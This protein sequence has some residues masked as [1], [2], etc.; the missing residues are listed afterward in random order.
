MS[1]CPP[2]P[3]IA[4][5]DLPKYGVPPAFLAGFAVVPIE[6]YISTSGVLG[7]MGFM[8]RERGGTNPDGTA[9]YSNEILSDAGASYTEP[10]DSVYAAVTFTAGSYIH[11][12]TYSIDS[13]G[14]VTTSGSGPTITASRYDLPTNLCRAKTDEALTM[15]RP[16]VSPPL[17]A[18][19]DAVRSHAASLVYAALKRARGATPPSGG[20]SGDDL[21][22][23]S[24]RRAIAFFL[25]IGEGGKPDSLSDTSST[26]GGTMIRPIR[27]R[28]LRGW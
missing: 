23:D 3:L 8:W 28:A 25:S 13:S 17:T 10:L 2:D 26:T 12:Q 5:A 18:W 22:F 15:M 24:E 14:T 19:G 7:T 6:I 9:A 4:A 16:A 21:V 11:T 20:Q 1:A 27:S